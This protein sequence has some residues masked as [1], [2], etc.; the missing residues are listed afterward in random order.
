MRYFSGKNAFILGTHARRIL[1]I[2]GCIT[3]LASCS[4]GDQRNPFKDEDPSSFPPGPVTQVSASGVDGGILVEWFGF[5]TATEYRVYWSDTPGVTKQNGNLATFDNSPGTIT[6]LTN[7]TTYYAI[8]TAANNFGESEDS[9]E[10][11]AVAMQQPP[12]P[13]TGVIAE[14]GNSE[15]TIEW[16]DLPDADSYSVFWGTNPGGGGTEVANVTSPYVVTGLTNSQTYYLSVTGTNAAGQG[17]PS[18]VVEATPV[19]PV[20]G[21]TA[22]TEINTPFSGL[23]NRATLEDVAI[24]DSGVAAALW[25]A[26]QSQFGVIARL[27]INHTATGDW[28]EQFVL[29]TADESAS[30]IVTPAGD[31]HVASDDSA[32]V[33]SRRYTNGAWEDAT[34]IRDDSSVTDS[35]GVE[36]AVDD[37]GNVFLCWV[38]DTIPPGVSNLESTHTLWV[39]RFDA[40]TEAWEAPQAISTSLSWIRSPKITAGASNTA[41]VSWLQDS[42]AHDVNNPSPP[43]QRVVYASRYDGVAWQSA[44]VVG[45]N[46]LMN[47]DNGEELVIAGNDAGSAVV[48]WTQTRSATGTPDALQIEAVRYD[49]GMSQWSAPENIVDG[50]TPAFR[51][52]IT[53]NAANTSLA[54]WVF[55]NNNLPSSSA[56]DPV[57]ALWGATTDIPTD[58]LSGGDPY[59]IESGESGAPVVAWGKEFQSPKGVFIRQ[60]D[61]GTGTWGATS[62]LGGRI[63]DQLL[64]AMSDNGHAIVMTRARVLQREDFNNVV[65]GSVF[66]P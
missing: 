65:Y 12:A 49:A 28:G 64:F 10:V 37:L 26:N 14:P 41:I 2:L 51:P 57:A 4:S 58:F 29:S 23:G 35:F 61:A 15:V 53:L 52:D 36:L 48:L 59:G 3:A 25:R 19:A 44:D 40:T 54:A 7:G 13:A 22:Q 18:R 17:S 45:R 16:N 1:I 63:G 62:H 50:V 9:A 20:P 47:L 60:F 30:V 21:W 31:I 38:E 32:T 33:R 46:D 5:V 11:Q 27:V 43:D 24:N 56:F 66:T 39:S 42:V 8:V 34:V 55:N 6:G